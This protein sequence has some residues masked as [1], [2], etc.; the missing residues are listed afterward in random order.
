MVEL[1]IVYDFFAVFLKLY[2]FPSLM[3]FKEVVSIVE[4]SVQFK[5]WRKSNSDF[6]AHAFVL[7]DEANK[8][9]WQIG[10]FNE[11]EKKATTFIFE[12]GVISIV[13]PQEIL[14]SGEKILLLDVNE[15]KITVEEAVKI[16]NEFRKLNY[17]REMIAKTFFIIQKTD[18]GALYNISFFS[19]S[20]NVVNIKLSVVDGKILKND[21]K[22]LAGFDKK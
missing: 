4:N 7:L 15:V 20:F 6:L 18:L 11:K 9:I 2:C 1:D 3:E 19:G 5:E 22:A 14:E 17:P 10:Y 13:P 12:N 8:D 16:A 21:M